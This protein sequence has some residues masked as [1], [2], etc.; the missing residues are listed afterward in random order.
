MQAAKQQH[1]TQAGWAE[2]AVWD[3]SGLVSTDERKIKAN[4]H[5]NLQHTTQVWTQQWLLILISVTIGVTNVHN[6]A[7]RY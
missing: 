3:G 5:T 6:V 2:T 4:E 7:M 1:T